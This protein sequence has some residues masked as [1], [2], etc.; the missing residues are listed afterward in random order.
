LRHA[1]S[2]HLL[3][4][5]WIDSGTVDHS[6]L[7]VPE[8]FG[9]MHAGQRATPPA[10]RRPDCLDDDRIAHDCSSPS[11]DHVHTDVCSEVSD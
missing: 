6:G 2:R 4:R 8:Q 7:H 5:G 11:P 9:G 1:A 3:D 10:N